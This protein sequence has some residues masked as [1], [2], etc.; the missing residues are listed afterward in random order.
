MQTPIRRLSKAVE[1]GFNQNPALWEEWVN[2]LTA[3]EIAL[4]KSAIEM[5]KAKPDLTIEEF[6]EWYE[7]TQ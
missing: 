6:V 4:L 5:A 7:L 3:A 2:T 1:K